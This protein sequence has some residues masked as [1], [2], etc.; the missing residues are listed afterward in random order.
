MKIIGEN[1][2]DTVNLSASNRKLSHKV[3]E[4]LHVPCKAANFKQFNYEMGNHNHRKT[5]SSQ[6]PLI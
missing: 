4:N 2:P 6:Y 5:H 3:A 1:K